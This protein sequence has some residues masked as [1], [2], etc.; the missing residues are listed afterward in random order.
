MKLRVV[1]QNGRYY[2][3]RQ[4][5]TA[6]WNGQWLYYEDASAERKTVSC[7]TEEEATNYILKEIEKQK[8]EVIKEWEV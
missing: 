6:S 8:I 2:P 1:K 7:K 4:V 5:K 3:Q